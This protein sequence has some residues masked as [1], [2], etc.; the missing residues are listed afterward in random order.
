M[1]S[2]PIGRTSQSTTWRARRGEGVDYAGSA[3]HRPS[4]RSASPCVRRLLLAPERRP[5]ALPGSCPLGPSNWSSISATTRSGSTTTK[6]SP[7]A[8]GIPGRSC[9]EAYGQSFVIDTTQHALIM[10]LHF[11]PAGA[12][13][14]IRPPVGELADRHIDLDDVWGP[15]AA[16]LRERLS[17]AAT[18][19][20]RFRLLK[21]ALTRR[22]SRPL[23]R[24]GAVQTALEAFERGDSPSV[25]DV[26][27][28]TG[29]SQRRFIQ[30]F[31]AQV[32][33]TPKLYQRLIGA[34]H[35]RPRR[36]STS[37]LSAGAR[38]LHRSA[39]ERAAQNRSILLEGLGVASVCRTNR[40]LGLSSSS[41]TISKAPR[42][43]RNAGMRP[44]ANQEL[45]SLLAVSRAIRIEH[46]Q[47]EASCS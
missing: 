26:V 18:P 15:A 23:E 8:T 24:H 28:R 35:P 32:G 21:E 42:R 44:V 36:A 31:A 46:A 41:P 29:L 40:T 16:E 38:V 20:E 33:M 10:G 3:V 6:A 22:A 4:R 37:T 14:F 5:I 34:P 2:S 27:G 19:A 39:G 7:A 11:K 12:F 17:A 9:S 30:V 13:P 45:R 47:S 1:G 25:R 43:A